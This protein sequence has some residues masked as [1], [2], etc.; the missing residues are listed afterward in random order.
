[1]FSIDITKLVGGFELQPRFDAAD[2]LVVLFGPSG[3]GKSLTL[4]A[5]AGLLTPD[6]GRIALPGGVVAF[7][8]EQRVN[9]PPQMRNVGYVVQQLALFPHMSARDNVEFGIADWPRARRRAQSD[10]LLSIL[11]LTGLEA[12][13]P[14]EMS[15]GQQQRVALARALA[16]EPSLLLLDE[17]FSALEGPLRTV[18]RRELQALRKR[19]NLTVLLVT[20]DLNEAYGLADRIVVYDDGRVLQQGT[21]QEIFRRPASRR[22]AELIETRNIIPGTIGAYSEGVAVV[23]TPFFTAR[24]RDPEAPV[25]GDVYLCIRPEHIL[26]LRE[27]HDAREASDVVL[28]AEIVDESATANSHRLYMNV[29]STGDGVTEPCVLEVDVPSHPYEVMGVA[30]KRSWRIALMS[31]HIALVPRA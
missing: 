5:V 3:S 14:R 18:L 13:R 4:Q 1:M 24:V 12:R 23:Q 7:D 19:L 16:A 27:G 30:S 29:G 11:G 17:P 22:V 9:L 26:V 15:G 31:E 28:D 6:Q 8:A 21:R 10:R 20:H 25:R 2:E